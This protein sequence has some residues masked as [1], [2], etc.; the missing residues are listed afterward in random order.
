MKRKVLFIVIIFVFFAIVTTFSTTVGF[1][2]DWLFFGEVGYGE[3]FKKI[4][5]TKAWIGLFFGVT[6]LVF[7]LVNVLIAN[8]SHFP[9]GPVFKVEGNVYELKKIGAPCLELFT[10]VQS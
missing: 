4:L 3:V 1:Y 7:L 5:L 9:Q 8:R 2:V 10:R 6:T